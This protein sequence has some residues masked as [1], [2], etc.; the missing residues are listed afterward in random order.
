MP[1]VLWGNVAIERVL[2]PYPEAGEPVQHVT[3]CVEYERFTLP[4]VNGASTSFYLL[5]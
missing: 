1:M 5:T 3:V 2:C 4:K